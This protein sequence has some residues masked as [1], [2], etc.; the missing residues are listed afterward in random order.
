MTRYS[1]RVSSRLPRDSVFGEVVQGAGHGRN[2]RIVIRRV[3]G[4]SA[5]TG[6]LIVEGELLAQ[7]G[8]GGVHHAVA[9][10]IGVRVLIPERQ[11]RRRGVGEEHAGRLEV[12][13]EG[14]RVDR[15]G[16]RYGIT[17]HQRHATGT[18]DEAPPGD[19]ET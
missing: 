18:G 9:V 12:D 7:R 10:E 17:L 6:Q 3:L 8:V 16:D 1:S 5:G 19:G 13:G 15:D 14:D 4:P 11:A 2:G